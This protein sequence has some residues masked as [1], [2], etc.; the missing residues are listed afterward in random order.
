MEDILKCFDNPSLFDGLETQ[1]FQRKY[2][3]EH[4]HLLVGY[5]VSYSP[6]I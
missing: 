3:K 1:Y 5:Y 6:I 4:F 2:Y